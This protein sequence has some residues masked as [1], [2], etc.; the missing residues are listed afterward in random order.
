MGFRKQLN[1]AQKTCLGRCGKLMQQTSMIHPGARIGVALSG[2]VDSW[3]MTMV[4]MLRQRIV[5]FDFEL[6]I[7][8][9]NPGFDPRNHHPLRS[10]LRDNPVAAH[11]EVTQ[12][13]PRSHDPG[14]T[15]SPCFLCSWERRKI[16]F[17]LCRKYRLTHLA[18]GHNSDDLAATF[19]MNLMQTGR[20]EGLSARESF[21][22][23]RL[24]VIRPLLMVEKKYIRNA[25]SRWSLPVWANPCPSAQTAK[26]AQ[27]EEILNSL[28]RKDRIYR[29]N[30]IN[31]LKRWQLDL[32]LQFN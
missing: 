13:G 30:I 14:H 17:N 11:V 15:K 2:G 10:W 6:M 29:K 28:Y 4:L 23:G 1:Y 22:E 12:T 20:V 5:P 7:L 31:A 32:N 18:L 27:M 26:R 8:H 25:A 9:V 3:V 19:F 24:T 21:F 16:L